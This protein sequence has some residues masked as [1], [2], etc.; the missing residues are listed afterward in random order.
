[1]WL[2][3]A[4]V[5]IDLLALGIFGKL[6]KVA[7]IHTS[8]TV[9]S[10]VR[11][12]NKGGQKIR[13]DFHRQYVESGYVAADSASAEEIGQML[14]GLPVI[15]QEVLDAGELECLA[16]LR[17]EEEIVFCTCDAA[18]IRALP[19]LGLSERG[20]SL[21]AVLQTSGLSSSQ[22]KDRHT[23]AY[24]KDNLSIGQKERVLAFGQP[25]KPTKRKG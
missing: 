21:E 7:E 16:I 20:A 5:I 17:R 19:F 8:S 14:S 25:E 23:E 18:A 2:L 4:D 1:L 24:F 22:L 13:V 9:A 15:R 12:F 3:D 11:F 6:V 10:E